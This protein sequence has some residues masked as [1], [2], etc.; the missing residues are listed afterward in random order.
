MGKDDVAERV[1]FPAATCPQRR[2]R[3]Q[4]LAARADAPTGSSSCNCRR[5][6][7]KRKLCTPSTASRSP[8]SARVS[9][10]CAAGQP[11]RTSSPSSRRTAPT[12]LSPAQPTRHCSKTRR[13]QDSQ[14]SD[15]PRRGDRTVSTPLTVR[16]ASP[17]LALALRAAVRRPSR[18]S[19]RTVRVCVGNDHMPWTEVV[20]APVDE[21]AS[22][23]LCPS[24]IR[25]K[26]WKLGFVPCQLRLF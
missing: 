7:T 20:E 18:L 10:R 17:S 26:G 1:R 9:A 3:L 12:G 5:S 16:G 24:G 4:L 23:S 14:R 25:A 15:H 21:R 11:L 6:S 19:R 8:S 22:G 13:S 2:T